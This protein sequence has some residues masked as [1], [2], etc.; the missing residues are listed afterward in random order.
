VVGPGARGPETETTIAVPDGTPVRRGETPIKFEALKEGEPVAVGTRKR[1]GRLTATAVQAGPGAA[2]V[3]ATPP[4]K[5]QP[6]RA[7]P[8]VRLLLRIAEQVLRE[9]ERQQEQ[10]P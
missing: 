9:V 4:P 3:H 8:R 10:G 1:D 5:R 6:G 7:L 2:T